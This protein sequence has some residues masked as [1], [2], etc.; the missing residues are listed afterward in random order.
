MLTVMEN[1]EVF[2]P[3]RFN[4]NFMLDFLASTVV[5]RKAVDTSVG[6]EST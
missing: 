4:F 1:N 2:F 3:P 6:F 5:L